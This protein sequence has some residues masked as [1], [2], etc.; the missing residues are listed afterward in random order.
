MNLK[1]KSVV[2]EVSSTVNVNDR[3]INTTAETVNV[4]VNVVVSRKLQ[5][6]GIYSC[7]NWF[8]VHVYYLK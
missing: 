6:H 8:R 4:T 1:L 5:L 3:I 7:R 2:N